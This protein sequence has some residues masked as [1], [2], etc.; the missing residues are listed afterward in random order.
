[1]MLSLFSTCLFLYQCV[2]VFE[3]YQRNDKI[4]SVKVSGPRKSGKRAAS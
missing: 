1:M 2:L 3:K 4:V